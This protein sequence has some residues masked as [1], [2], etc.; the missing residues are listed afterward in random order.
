VLFRALRYVVL[1]LPIIALRITERSVNRP[2]ERGLVIFL[3]TVATFVIIWLGTIVLVLKVLPR[4]VSPKRLVARPVIAGAVVAAMP[5]HGAKRGFVVADVLAAVVF[6][7]LAVMDHLA[8]S[9][10]HWNPVGNRTAPAV[11]G[12]TERRLVVAFRNFEFVRVARPVINRGVLVG[13]LKT[14]QEID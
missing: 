8:A 14:I 4:T 13:I 6:I 1:Q 3:R 5:L 2:S 10:D 9:A 7:A 12:R 11:T